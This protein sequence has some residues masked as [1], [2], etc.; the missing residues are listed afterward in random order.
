MPY[1]GLRHCDDGGTNPWMRLLGTHD[2]FC[3]RNEVCFSEA[4][5]IS[6]QAVPEERH[7]GCNAFQHK[8]ATLFRHRH[9]QPYRPARGKHFQIKRTR[10]DL[11]H[12][13]FRF[14]KLPL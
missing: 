12:R 13:Q 3:V 5:K 9:R 14:H 4:M 6:P 8:S 1:V 10:R 7:R 2:P 11:A